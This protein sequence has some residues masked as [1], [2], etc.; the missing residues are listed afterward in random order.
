MRKNFLNHSF[1][2][3]HPLPTK[4]TREDEEDHSKNASQSSSI[5]KVH[6]FSFQKAIETF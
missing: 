5:I 1:P 2:I 3:T 4:Y 6:Q